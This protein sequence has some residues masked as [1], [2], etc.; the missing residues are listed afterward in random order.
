MALRVLTFLLLLFLHFFAGCATVPRADSASEESQV[1]VVGGG[2]AGLTAARELEKRGIRVALLEAIERFGGR[3]ATASYGPGLTAEFGMQEIWEKSPL[4][5]IA[6]E[7][8]L[9][10]E[11]DIAYSSVLLGGKLYPFTQDTAEAYFRAVFSPEELTAHQAFLERAAALEEELHQRGLTERLRPL[12]D[13]SFA[14][15]L[16][17]TQVPPRVAEWARLTLECELGAPA[18][19]FSALS[20]IAELRMFLRGG[21]KAFSVVGG[22][23]QLIERLAASLRGPKR[24]GA[25]VTSIHRA[26]DARG[27]WRVT[28]RYLQNNREHVMTAERVV[29]AVPWLMLHFLQLDPPLGDEVWNAVYTIG[30]GQYT[31]VHLLLDRE[32]EALFGEV[33]PFPVLTSGPLGVIYGPSPVSDPK[34]PLRVFSLLV[35]GDDARAFHL[36]PHEAKRDALVAELERL[37]P[38]FA[39]HV[40]S[41]AIYPYHPAAVPYWPPGRSP[42]DEAAQLLFRA[43]DGLRLAGD[44]LVSS[45]SEGAVVSAL[46]QADAIARELAAPEQR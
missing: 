26:Q 42:Y 21:E 37:W 22:N 1:V 14:D 40:R 45:H 19:R 44:Y 18:D 41:A 11:E 17:E 4:L 25:K 27:R 20:G 3:V 16:V 29:V 36:A 7:L 33:S 28:V 30:R 39:R 46:K 23:G 32:V 34:L 15:W 6:R 35:H 38:G 8:G 13:T 2:L 5:S 31:V 43:H 12:Q 10:L 24:T 9:P